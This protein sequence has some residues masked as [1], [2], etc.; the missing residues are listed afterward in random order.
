MRHVHIGCYVTEFQEYDPAACACH[1]LASEL[2]TR[3][4]SQP[5]VKLLFEYCFVYRSSVALPEGVQCVITPVDTPQCVVCARACSTCSWS[6]GEEEC[7]ANTKAV[8][9][10]LSQ[11]KAVMG[12]GDKPLEV[13]TRR[14]GLL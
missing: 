5:Y 14:L 11:A 2:C 12:R 7:K 9:S 3:S 8:W 13:P 6:A 10:K 1:C 4:R